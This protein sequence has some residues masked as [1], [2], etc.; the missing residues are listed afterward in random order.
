MLMFLIMM[1]FM[2]LL[3][4]CTTTGG[5][6]SD[7]GTEDGETTDDGTAN[8]GGSGDNIL[9]LN[10]SNE[11]TSLDSTQA[12]DNVSYNILNNLMEGL[13]RLG[14]THEPEEATAE[15]WEVSDDGLTYT[16]TIR[17]NANWSNGE[18]VTAGDFEFAWKR[19]A[20][21]ETA[22]DAA[23]LTDL[24]EGASEFNSGEG[25][26]DDMAV[27]AIDEKTLEVTL[28]SPQAYFLSIISNP[29]FFPVHQETVEADA[30]WAAEA[31]TFVGNGPFA[32]TGW[33]HNSNLTMDKNEEYWDADSVQLDGVV[34]EMVNDPNTEYQLFQTGELHTSSVPTELAEQLIADG[35]VD[36]E[37]QSGTYFYR[38]NTEMEPFQNEKIRKAFSMA[39]DQQEI[40]DY[41]T[42][43]E[44]NAAHGFVAYG[45]LEPSGEDF[46]EVGGDLLSFD[47]TKAQSLL[48][49][50][51]EEEGYTE[52][53]DITLS[54][55]TSDEHKLI[56]EVL[57]DMFKEHLD[58]DVTLA[59][60]EWN[61]F[62]EAQQ[63]LEMQ[64]SRSSFI[65][66]FADPINYLE[67]FVTGSSMNRTGWSNEEYDNLIAA[68]KAEADEEA[69]FD[70][71]HQAE[72]ILMEEAPIFPIY[73]YNQPLLQADEVSG[74]VRHPVGYIE[75]KWASLE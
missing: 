4:A 74:I 29:A 47:P 30:S 57:Q 49:E 15:N 41:V 13:T 73:F 65:A 12:F 14:E 39:V 35:E 64:F 34:W 10:N 25:T 48:A 16:F 36:F 27:T 53:P 45:F 6:D 18:P 3:V 58:V 52:L 59:N 22:A 51:M 40:V 31:D 28:T 72:E 42:K 55:N 26:A 44:E 43:R 46:R 32:I 56:A 37:D 54:Y 21:P 63:N 67:S 5:T 17:E 66:D 19:L 75:L 70:L 7:N 62:L 50:G 68:A 60:T 2:M 20:D 11:P 24:I 61:V 8:G 69:R 1:A 23:F 38:F 71:M 9:R 33:N